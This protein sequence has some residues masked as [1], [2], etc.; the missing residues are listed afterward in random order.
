MIA[1]RAEW[2]LLAPIVI[3]GAALRN[4]L[5]DTLVTAWGS[6]PF[7]LGAYSAARPGHADAR[8]ALATPVSPRLH[9][10]GEACSVNYFGTV[11]GAWRS[12][13]AAAA[14]LL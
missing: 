13:L 9:F 2:L 14:R 8:P 7:A 4:E 10:A 3:F 11:H 12:G 5:G 1:S 6:D